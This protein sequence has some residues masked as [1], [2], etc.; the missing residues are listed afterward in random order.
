M[1]GW[2]LYF[3]AISTR[4]QSLGA[5][6]LTVLVAVKTMVGAA[7]TVLGILVIAE[8]LLTDDQGRKDY[9]AATLR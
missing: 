8:R 9:R 7:A 6:G 4:E 2:G 5:P 3:L 1:T